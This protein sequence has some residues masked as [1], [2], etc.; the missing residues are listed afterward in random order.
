VEEV[1]WD[2]YTWEKHSKL[3]F[4]IQQAWINLCTRRTLGLSL[5]TKMEVRKEE[6]TL[7]MV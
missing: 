2:M 5:A 4:H 1:K 7:Y 6:D 3:L